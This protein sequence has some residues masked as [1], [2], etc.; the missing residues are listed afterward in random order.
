MTARD[1]IK[2]YKEC[3][4]ERKHVLSGLVYLF[5]TQNFLT[6]QEMEKLYKAS[7]AKHKKIFTEAVEAYKKQKEAE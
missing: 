7:S 4:L 5:T 3:D 2:A 6:P 1:F